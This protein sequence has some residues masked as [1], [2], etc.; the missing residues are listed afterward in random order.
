MRN[1]DVKYSHDFYMRD[2]NFTFRSVDVAFNPIIAESDPSDFFDQF[3]LMGDTQLVA[4]E[5]KNSGFEH[6]ARYDAGATSLI[7]IGVKPQ[8]RWSAIRTWQENEQSL[9]NNP[10]EH[11]MVL[12]PVNKF[13]QVDP[14]ERLDF[15]GEPI[16]AWETPLVPI[17]DF[18]RAGSTLADI[19]GAYHVIEKIL[20]HMGITHGLS[21]MAVMPNDTLVY[22]DPHDVYDEV[23]DEDI[24]QKITEYKEV[25]KAYPKIS[26]LCDYIVGSQTVQQKYFLS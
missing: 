11:P 9:I 8:D 16:F 6:A 22:V 1:N 10:I 26:H 15:Y 2:T 21:A 5:I 24:V 13:S 20:K 14:Q 19:H 12:Q 7:F 3:L 23:S 18:N 4:S 17:I 25:T